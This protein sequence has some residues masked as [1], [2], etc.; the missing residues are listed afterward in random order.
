M[1]ETTMRKNNVTAIGAPKN[2]GEERNIPH[3]YLN[4]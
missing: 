2:R 4:H 1:I 3:H